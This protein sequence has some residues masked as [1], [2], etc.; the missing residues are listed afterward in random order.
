MHCT[1]VGLSLVGMCFLLVQVS[2]VLRVILS[3]VS[4]NC[5]ERKAALLSCIPATATSQRHNILDLFRS[6]KGTRLS[7]NGDQLAAGLNV[8]Y[9]SSHVSPS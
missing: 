1:V 8:L 6:T 3:H 9:M 7:R 5:L 4:E 2:D